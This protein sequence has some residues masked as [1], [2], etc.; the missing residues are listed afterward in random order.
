[1]L[2]IMLQNALVLDAPAEAT[3]MAGGTT[4][5][6]LIRAGYGKAAEIAFAADNGKVWLVLAPRT[7][8]GGRK[9]GIVTQRSIIAGVSPTA[10]R[11][12][13]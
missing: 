11:G 12:R 6:V 10:L 9:P 4:S 13:R 3:A 8:R 1:V 2:K 7:N 5:I